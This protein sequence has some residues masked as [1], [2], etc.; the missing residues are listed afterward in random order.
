VS[1]VFNFDTE[2]SVSANGDN[3]PMCIIWQYISITS[4]VVIKK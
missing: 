2:K 1:V 4:R 3:S